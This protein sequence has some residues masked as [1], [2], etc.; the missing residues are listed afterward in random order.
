MISGEIAHHLLFELMVAEWIRMGAL[1]KES[2]LWKLCRS[3]GCRRSHREE[4]DERGKIETTR[5][6]SQDPIF[7][8]L[9]TTHRPS[10]EM[11]PVKT[12]KSKRSLDTKEV[13]D[14]KKPKTTPVAV[15]MADTSA[16]DDKPGKKSNVKKSAGSKDTTTTKPTVNVDR[17]QVLSLLKL[18]DHT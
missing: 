8:T 18:W 11:A 3:R 4:R 2:F 9:Q 5:N 1:P 7:L 16:V 6:R 10:L 15:V 12:K 13:A 17:K 14:K